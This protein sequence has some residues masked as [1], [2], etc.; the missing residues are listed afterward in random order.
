[1]VLNLGFGVVVAL[2]LYLIGIPYAYVW[3][4]MAALLRYIPFLGGWIAAAFPLLASLGLPEWTPFFLTAIFFGVIELVQANL[5]EPLV[6]GRSI[7]VSAAGQLVAALFWACLWGPVGLI[8]STPL[9]ACL[10]VLGHH[11]PMLHFFSALMGDE[12]VVEKPAAFYQRLLAGDV[13]EAT[14]LVWEF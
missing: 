7:G 1:L 13:S 5:V 10:C 12:E 3:G 6:F 8:L 9:T 11:F 2:G 14:E 4:A